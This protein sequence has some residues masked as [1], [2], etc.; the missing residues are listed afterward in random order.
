[1]FEKEFGRA[2]SP[3]EYQRIGQWIEEDEY[4]PDLIQLAL[5]E[6]VLNQAYSLNYIDR[7]LLSWERKNI[8]TEQQVEEEQKRRKRKMLN[9][10]TTRSEKE[11]PNVSLHNW[12]EEDNNDQ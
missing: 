10:E 8:T 1:M 11:L 2:L 6:A 12:L 7:V 3:I 9:K 4:S 5:K